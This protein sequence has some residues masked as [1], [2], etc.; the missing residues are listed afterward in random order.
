MPPS[1]MIR[2]LRDLD[3]NASSHNKDT[4]AVSSK[5]YKSH[6]RNVKI[7]AVKGLREEN[8]AKALL[9]RI[10][11]EFL[12]LL[13]KRG[14]NVQS[15]SE[16]CCCGDGLPKSKIME[17]NVLGYNRT[18]IRG[19]HNKS[20]TIH[21]RLRQPH[22]HDVF[23]DYESISGTMSHELAH[24]EIAPHNAR[25]YK[26][27]EEIQDQHA[28]FLTKGI[29]A[30]AQGFPVGNDQAYTLGKSRTTT[31]AGVRNNS[32][33]PKTAANSR[34]AAAKA[35]LARQQ[36]QQVT[37]GQRLG[38]TTGEFTK[39]LRPGEAAGMAAEQRR[40]QD[41]VWCQPCEPEIIELSDDEEEDYEMDVDNQSKDSKENHQDTKLP[42][43]NSL[44]IPSNGGDNRGK[45]AESKTDAT[46][47]KMPIDRSTVPSDAAARMPS[48][49]DLVDLTADDDDDDIVEVCRPPKQQRRANPDE[50]QW[51]C[52]TCTFL[53]GQL[54]LVCGMCGT[55][56]A[57]N[58][59]SSVAVAQ[60]LHN[61]DVETASE[62][63]VQ[64]LSRGDQVEHVKDQE[65]AQSMRDFGFNIYGNDKQK[66]S[67]MKHMT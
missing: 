66:S 57:D 58:A 38:G 2:T 60:E 21:L 65:V 50:A 43:V 9:E 39:W 56:A 14:Y 29:V 48:S 62:R 28:V 59:Q 13:Q 23:F 5:N 40:L 54:A 19:R 41:E 25:F 35:A 32:N 12:P 11:Q 24:C 64:E 61:R 36:R 15:V 6:K 53:N 10:H 31:N 27:M 8:H 55:V 45:S 20:H 22:N 37:G 1:S 52:P 4:E 63:L 18:T 47:R 33:P 26:L 3:R 17:S 42:A 30:D 46:I 44:S 7:A 51:S 49:S 16:M 67:K 34:N